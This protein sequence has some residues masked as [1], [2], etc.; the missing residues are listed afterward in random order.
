MRT[1]ASPMCPR[2]SN[3]MAILAHRLWSSLFR[4]GVDIRRRFLCSE[5]STIDLGLEM[6]VRLK[7]RDSYQPQESSDKENDLP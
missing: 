4:D 1:V 7:K 6:L 2:P 5:W 3:R